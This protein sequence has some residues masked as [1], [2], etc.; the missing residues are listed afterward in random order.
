MQ[1]NDNYANRYIKPDPDN[2]GELRSE[3]P[4]NVPSLK[5]DGDIYSNGKKVLVDDIP[6]WSAE[7][8]GGSLAHA[9]TT[10]LT[11]SHL[12]ER[13]DSHNALS[14]GTY[15]IPQSGFYQ[16]NGAVQCTDSGSGRL[17]LWIFSNGVAGQRME[18]TGSAVNHDIGLATTLAAYFDAGD[19]VYLGAFQES[20]ATKA[21]ATGNFSGFLVAR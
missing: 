6:R 15:T 18:T 16:I 19:T 9:S 11:S 20:G 5:S 2:F 21:L 3:V 8:T 4:L 17:I 12:T 1:F 14:N 13:V 7:V 10:Y